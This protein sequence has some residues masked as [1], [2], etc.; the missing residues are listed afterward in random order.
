M[1]AAGL[2]AVQ[3]PGNHGFQS[4][5]CRTESVAATVLFGISQPYLDVRHHLYLYTGRLAYLA[6]ILDVYSR[7]V[8]GWSMQERLADELVTTAFGAALMQRK[9]QAGLLVHSDRGFQYSGQRFRAVLSQHECT[10]SV[11]ATGNCFDKGL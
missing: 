7:R 4:H 1:Q 6:V 9:P 2:R 3:I 10:Q 5:G 8:V 11:S